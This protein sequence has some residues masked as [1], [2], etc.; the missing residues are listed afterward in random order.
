MNASLWSKILEYDFDGPMSEYG[1]STRLA[2]ENFWTK[3]FTKKAILEY[4]KFMYL[5]ATSDMMV[6]PSE[7]IDVVWHQHLIFTQSYSDFCHVIGKQIQ[8][9]PSTHNHADF[10]KFKLAKER[11]NKMYTAIFG[12]QPSEIW[13][14]RGMFESLKLDKAKLKLRGFV[15]L[16][17]FIFV[18][19]V[20]PFYYLLRPVYVQ[21]GNPGFAIGFI[22]LASLAMVGMEL[23]NRRYLS[24]V[25]RGLDPK[26]FLFDLHPME[27]IYLKTQKIAN[28]VN[29]TLSQ[30]VSDRKVMVLNDHTMSAFKDSKPSTLEEYTVLET[31]ALNA[32]LSYSNLLTLIVDRPVFGNTKSCM[33]SFKKYFLKSK[34][35]GTLFY[36]NFGVLSL[37][38]MAGF[39]RLIT[40]ML[41]E[42][43]VENLS[44]LLIVLLIVIVLA[45]SRLTKL[46]CTYTVPQLYKTRLLR[47][48]KNVDDKIINDWNWQYFMLGAAV[49]ASDF[50]PVVSD[51][52]TGGAS[53]T[54]SDSSS[55]CGSSCSSCGGC[56]GD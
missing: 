24:A 50:A 39:I 55:S 21:I 53:I 48:K 29:G 22:I 8:H 5:A 40:G 43:P 45:L 13:D 34:K 26:C 20:I 42:R 38:A 37:V 3:N 51:A 6:S 4:K 7:V 32:K 41:R 11:T 52:G 15:L 27:V 17:I 44:I 31:L 1:F 16:G 10:E 33:D 14:Y 25:V 2:G 23:Y 36:I 46:V 12:E 18:C 30:L 47:E 9:V 35:F 49:F 56:G 19:L 28:V 54:S